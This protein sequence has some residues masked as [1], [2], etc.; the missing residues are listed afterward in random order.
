MHSWIFTRTTYLNSTLDTFSV[1]GTDFIG[2]L[3]IRSDGNHRRETRKCCRKRLNLCISR[4]MNFVSEPGYRLSLSRPTLL[5][6]R[7]LSHRAHKR[8]RPELLRLR[9]PIHQRRM[10]S[11]RAHKLFRP[12]LLRPRQS[13][14]QPQMA[15]RFTR[16]STRRNRSQH[17]YAPSTPS[18]ARISTTKRSPAS[19]R[20][21][22]FSRDIQGVRRRQLQQHAKTAWRKN[23]Q[24]LSR[25]LRRLAQR[26]KAV[27]RFWGR[28]QAARLQAQSRR[29]RRSTRNRR[30]SS[31]K[32]A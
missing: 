4:L 11:Q 26:R 9:Q 13:I 28:R 8:F 23:N 6:S 22:A 7:G 25:L 31:R 16:T 24:I 19:P 15:V 3:P 18:P 10:L 1:R 17:R 2:F 14:H 32:K 21:A 29:T 27:V 20:F 5:Q 12:S 30:A